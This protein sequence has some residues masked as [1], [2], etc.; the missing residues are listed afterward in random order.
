MELKKS[1]KVVAAVI[2]DN[3]DVLCMQRGH[4]KFEYTSYKWEFPGGKIEQGESPEEALYR[5]I[6][7]EISMD[8]RIDQHL[9]TVEH[10]YPD[11][12]IT[13]VAFLC[14]PNAG[15]TFTMNEHHDH[16]WLAPKQLSTLDWAAADIGIVEA[17]SSSGSIQ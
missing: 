17:I 7:E 2:V 10:E 8:I 11:F 4:T 9:I 14:T 1:I 3:G 5:E 12:R 16:Q 6:R 15:R 13:M